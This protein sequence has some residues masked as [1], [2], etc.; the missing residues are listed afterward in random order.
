MKE[1][2]YIVLGISRG[3][4]K[5]RI[6]QAYRN[7]AKRYHPD[8]GGTEINETKFKEIQK[9]YETLSDRERRAIYDATLTQP[10]PPPQSNRTNDIINPQRSFWRKRMNRRSFVDEFFEGWLPGSY[11]PS[12]RA[13]VDKSLAIE[14]TL[15]PSEARHGGL[16]PL[17]VPVEE[18]CSW[19]SQSGFQYPFVCSRCR[20]RGWVHAERSFS[21]SVPPHTKDGTEVR[22]SLEDIGLSGVTLYL[23]IRVAASEWG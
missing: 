12:D 7:M 17:A 1:N 14:M 10:T 22:I 13:R 4:S 2:Y 9:A 6:K 19:C 3:A 18:P 21:V 20:G 15:D 23:F 16:F 5:Q 8:G 11:F